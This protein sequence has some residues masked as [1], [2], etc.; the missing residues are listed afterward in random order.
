MKEKENESK[1]D[2]VEEVEEKATKSE[3]KD[4]VPKQDYDELLSFKMPY[5]FFVRKIT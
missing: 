4:M 1:E 2:V 5:S 3:N